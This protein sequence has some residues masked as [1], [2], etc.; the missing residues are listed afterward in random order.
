MCLDVLTPIVVA[1]KNAEGSVSEDYVA[2]ATG[3]D[4]AVVRDVVERL[5]TARVLLVTGTT[6]RGVSQIVPA[7]PMEQV[8]LVEVVSL[9]ASPGSRLTDAEVLQQLRED[10]WERL[11]GL[12]EG[13]T[14]GD[15]ATSQVLD[16]ETREIIRREADSEVMAG[17]GEAL[18]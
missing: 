1:Y 8:S 2:F 11:L 16:D 7:R 17:E 18:A 13:K 6:R 10:H 14:A 4:A 9:F 12:L 3:Y 5:V 15:L